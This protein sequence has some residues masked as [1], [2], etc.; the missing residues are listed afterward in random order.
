MRSGVGRSTPVASSYKEKVATLATPNDTLDFSYLL[1]HAKNRVPNHICTHR[2]LLDRF[3]VCIAASSAID[4]ILDISTCCRFLKDSLHFN[5][6]SLVFSSR[7]ASHS[8]NFITSYHHNIS[9]SLVSGPVALQTPVFKI[10]V[11]NFTAH[12]PVSTLHTVLFAFSLARCSVMY[13]DLH[14]SLAL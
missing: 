7:T 4:E 13:S 10:L 5:S 2:A 11:F 3:F 12:L 14:P 9:T 8:L 6:P 1:S